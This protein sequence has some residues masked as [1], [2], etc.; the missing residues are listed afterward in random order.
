MFLSV[1]VW[2]TS[3]FI[4]RIRVYFSTDNIVIKFNHFGVTV[5]VCDHKAWFA[6]LEGETN[7]RKLIF[8]MD[9]RMTALARD[10][11]EWSQGRQRIKLHF[12]FS[13]WF[14]CINYTVII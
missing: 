12:K 11:Y 8:S 10:E 7:E 1:F 2:S 4:T 3:I 5:C 14:A 13:W 9:G 6:A